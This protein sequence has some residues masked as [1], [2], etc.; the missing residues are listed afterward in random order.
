MK[1]KNSFANDKHQLELFE[2]IDIDHLKQ[3]NK[4]S[5]FQLVD[6]SVSYDDGIYMLF[7]ESLPDRIDGMFVSTKANS[8]YTA[9]CIKLDWKQSLVK[10]VQCYNLGLLDYNYHFL[11]PYKDYFL[12]LGARCKKHSDDEAENNALI[13]SREGHVIKEFCLGD[14][15]QDCITTFDDKI[16]LS[17]FDEGVFGNYGWNNPLGSSGLIVWDEFGRKIWENKKYDIVDCYAINIDSQSRLWFY[18]YVNFDLVCTDY[19]SD[20]ILNPQISGAGAFAIS[21]TINRIIMSGGYNDDNFYLYDFDES[22]S[23]IGKREA[24]GFTLNK[25]AVCLTQ[26]HFFNAN[27]LFITNNNIL[28]GYFFE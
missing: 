26:Y 27:L 17:Y 10:D 9:I 19:E 28:C 22:R 4:I 2:I 8:N 16:I 6:F 18:Y 5:S 12:L 7:S 11:R 23:K 21:K 14:G 15:I 24:V 20:L 3:Q 25:G 13:L 1:L